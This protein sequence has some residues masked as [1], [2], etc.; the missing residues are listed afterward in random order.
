M[1]PEVTSKYFS[2]PTA[3]SQPSSSS[4]QL[5]LQPVQPVVVSNGVGKL[6]RH[7]RHSRLKRDRLEDDMERRLFMH[8]GGGSGGDMHIRCP[9]CRRAELSRRR[10][11]TW[12]LAHMFAWSR[13]GDMALATPAELLTGP[14][15]LGALA[16]LVPLCHACNVLAETDE[17]GANQLDGL[18]RAARG[19]PVYDGR[20]GR[21]MD[22]LRRWQFVYRGLPSPSPDTDDDDVAVEYVRRVFAATPN[23]PG[24]VTEPGVWAAYE[25]WLAVRREA[26]HL[27]HNT[28]VYEREAAAAAMQARAARIR[29]LEHR[30]QHASIFDDDDNDNDNNNDNDDD[31]DNGSGCGG[32]GGGTNKNKRKK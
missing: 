31:D 26:V 22:L 8:Y 23:Q 7:R 14:S 12:V 29:E 3:A 32:G 30:R 10:R 19:Q 21:L 6:P 11:E 25:R 18:F 2:A 28:A 1:Q 9:C 13:G 27:R 24:G 4:E 15:M 17:R 16:N 5:L 20:I